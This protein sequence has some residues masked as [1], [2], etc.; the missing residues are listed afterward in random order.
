MTI[1][2]QMVVL[3]RLLSYYGYHY[4]FT[5]DLPLLTF[6]L[7]VTLWPHLL[8]VST[9]LQIRNCIN[10]CWQGKIVK[11]GNSGVNCSMKRMYI[12]PVPLPA[13]CSAA[14]DCTGWPRVLT[15][16]RRTCSRTRLAQRNFQHNTLKFSTH[17]EEISN[18]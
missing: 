9:M 14:R 5:A 2:K 8:K 12:I 3:L 10:S 17:V 4:K 18:N 1:H 16:T 6:S 11:L 7:F 15:N 13:F